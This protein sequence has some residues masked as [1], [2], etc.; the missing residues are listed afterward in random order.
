MPMDPR[1]PLL[2]W[3]HAEDYPW[4]SRSR[5]TH[6]A[7]IRQHIL[8]HFPTGQDMQALEAWLRTQRG[9]R[10]FDRRG[11][12]GTAADSAGGLT[13]SLQNEVAKLRRLWGLASQLRRS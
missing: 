1:K 6:L 8:R 4:H 2:L 12:E 7:L 5:D 10:G 3:D 11:V 13:R 9:P